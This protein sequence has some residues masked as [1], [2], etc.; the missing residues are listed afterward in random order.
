MGTHTQ[1]ERN[2]ASVQLRGEKR[3]LDLLTLQLGLH[4]AEYS[5]DAEKP[6]QTI[7][8]NAI[9]IVFKANNLL[10]HRFCCNPSGYLSLGDSDAKQ[11]W[12]TRPQNQWKG[13]KRSLNRYWGWL[14][15]SFYKKGSLGWATHAFQQRSVDTFENRSA[16]VTQHWQ[17]IF[18]YCGLFL[19]ARMVRRRAQASNT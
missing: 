3:G 18:E 16:H 5:M 7:T 19:N 11:S 12:T 15:R 4:A 10:R 2:C 9:A 1:R 14:K 17:T 6:E 8:T 13:R